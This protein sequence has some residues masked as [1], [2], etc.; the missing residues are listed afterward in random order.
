MLTFVTPL[1]KNIETGD[2]TSEPKIVEYFRSMYSHLWLQE[3]KQHIRPSR[4]DP[5][6]G[7]TWKSDHSEPPTFDE[8]ACW[9]LSNRR[10]SLA[11]QIIA[12]INAAKG[13]LRISTYAFSSLEAGIGNQVLRA[14]IEADEGGATAIL[15]HATSTAIGRPRG[16]MNHTDSV[17]LLAVR[18]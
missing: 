18:M 10:M 8:D 16:N 1:E 5:R 12:T 15:Y 11:K 3:A 6:L 14:I 9:T 13:S 17:Q 7:N 2:L 4:S